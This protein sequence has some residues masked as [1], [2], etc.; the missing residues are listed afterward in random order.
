MRL[1][2]FV[3]AQKAEFPVK[4]LCRVCDVSRAGYHDWVCRLSAG[5]SPR[6]AAEAELVGQIRLVHKESRGRYGEPRVTAQ[7]HRDGVGA[8]HKAVERL[9]AREGLQGRCGRRKV[10]TTTPDR[11]ATPAP[12]LVERDFQRDELDE[13]WV[14]DCTY[15]PTDEGWL[16]LAGVA[17]ACSRRLLGWSIAD[18]LRTEICTDA[19]EAAVGTR[20]KAHIGATGVIFHSDH[21]CQ[22]TSGEYTK[23]CRRLGITQSMGS[24]GD[25]FDNALCEA[26]WSGFKREAVEGERFATKAEAR[27]AIFAWIIWYNTTR[28]HSSLGQ[29]PPVEYENMLAGAR[30]AAA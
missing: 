1:F 4:T 6:Q 13:L 28:L 26:I 11:S 22:Y 18:H 2:A 29:R 12:D 7:L 25:S 9:M 3:D 16:Y 14:G 19:L 20:G 17:D 30:L 15:I 10:R 27:A 8:N 5:P 21:G 24:V 23:L